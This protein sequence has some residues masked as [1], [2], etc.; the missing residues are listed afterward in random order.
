[1]LIALADAGWEWQKLSRRKMLEAVPYSAGA[2][3][4]WHS[5]GPTSIDTAYLGA[6]LDADKLISFGIL[7]IP[8]GLP[9][10]MYVDMMGGRAPPASKL[11]ALQ[12]PV[13]KAGL[14]LELDGGSFGAI[15]AAMP[16]KT[17]PSME[18]PGTAAWRV[19]ARDLALLLVA[20]VVHN[21][22]ML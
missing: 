11:L 8:H 9:S 4:T 21:H 15:V 22:L 16:L 6:L 19:G 17:R 20:A 10:A 1:V 7:A 12:A 13:I 3:K 18:L 14:P 5:T 2:K